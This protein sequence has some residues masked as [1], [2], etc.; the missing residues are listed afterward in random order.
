MFIFEI[1]SFS[2]SF[3]GVAAKVLK[4]AQEN[5][6]DHFR[7][8]FNDTIVPVHPI[9]DTVDSL[10]EYYIKARAIMNSQKLG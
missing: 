4:I 5:P 1:T 10:Q 3:H 8:K 2:G 7:L 9:T 6:E